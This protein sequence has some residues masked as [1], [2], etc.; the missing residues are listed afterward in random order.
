MKKNVELLAREVFN[1]LPL[2]FPI[3]GSG[4]DEAIQP[5]DGKS[6]TNQSH[7]LEVFAPVLEPS[8]A[9]HN[10]NYSNGSDDLPL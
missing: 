2:F 1:P 9:K 5:S 10:C 4:Y 6:I 3:D 7:A 8:N